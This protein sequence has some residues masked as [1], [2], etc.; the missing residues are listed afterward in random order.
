MKEL[1]DDLGYTPEGT[2]L[3]AVICKNDV[4]AK[5]VIEA[6]QEIGFTSDNFPL[7]TGSDCDI[8]GV[9]N[10]LDGYQSMSLFL[11]PD[12]LGVKAANLVDAIINNKP[13]SSNQGVQT[14]SG[15][16]PAFLSEPIVCTEENYQELLLD[17]G[18]YDNLDA[19]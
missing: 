1:I 16:V 10:M 14:D 9:K 18:Y 7:V 3:D 13:L 4:I 2:R 5:G 19:E 8:I 12:D 15:K 6:L 17:S 11:N